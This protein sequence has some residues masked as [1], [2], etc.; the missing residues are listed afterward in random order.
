MPNQPDS[1]AEYA[2]YSFI[3]RHQNLSHDLPSGVL[4]NKFMTLLDNELKDIKGVDMHLPH[5]WYRWGDEVVRYNMPYVTWNHDFSSKTTVS[6]TGRIPKIKHRNDVVRF[7][8]TF[9][10]DF[11]ERYSG[12]EGVELAIDEVYSRAPFRFQN[13]F[14]QLRENLKPSQRNP[15]IINHVEIVRN[16]YDAAMSVYPS[17]DFKH[18][19][20]Q[21]IQFKTIFSKALENGVSIDRLQQISETFWFFFCYHLRLNPRC[22]FNV[23]KETLDIW[24]SALPDA[25]DDYEEKMQNYAYYLYRGKS[26]DPVASKLI[27]DRRNRLETIESLIRAMDCGDER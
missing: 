9:V 17:D 1:Y 2:A 13:D 11:I 18:I 8:D 5:C 16:L 21:T 25:L 23:T 20:Y 22:H 6:Y 24:E 7:T 26:D 4:F 12:V 19:E 15:A 10:D 27:D 14:R 3:S